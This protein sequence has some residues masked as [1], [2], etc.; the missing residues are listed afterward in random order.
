M[1][2]L[3]RPAGARLAGRDRRRAAA[4]ALARRFGSTDFWGRWTRVECLAKLADVPVATWWH[5]H[6]LE[7]PPGTAWLWRTLPLDDL[8]VTV[9]FTPATP[10]ERESGTFP[11]I[12]VS[13]AG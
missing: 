2:R 3:V 1:C 13:G 10:I 12:A 5:R 7:V 9:A 6:G 8:V 11:D 4:A